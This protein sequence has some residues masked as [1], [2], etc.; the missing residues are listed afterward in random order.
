M[1]VLILGLRLRTRWTKAANLWRRLQLE[2]KMIGRLENAMI[3]ILPFSKLNEVNKK[4]K[5][6]SFGCYVG[7]HLLPRENSRYWQVIGRMPLVGQGVAIVIY[8]QALLF[9]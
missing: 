7:Y 5:P 4:D 3:I 2:K 6:L 8:T 9:C 1:F